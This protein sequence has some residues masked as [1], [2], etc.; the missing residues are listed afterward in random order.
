MLSKSLIQCS[1]DGRGCVPSLLFDLRP[2]YGGGN[3]DN[4]NLLQ[5]FPHTQCC[6]QFPRPCSRPPL[7]QA[8]TSDSWTLTSKSGSVSAPP[9][10]WCTQVSVCALQESVPPVLCKFWQFYGGV[11]GDLLQEGLCRTQVYCMQQS[12]YPC[13]SSLLTCTSAGDTLT[14]SCLSL[15]GV[16]WFWCTQDLFK[17]SQHL[18]Q[19][20]GLILNVISSL[21]PTCLLINYIFCSQRW[22]SSTQS[23]KTRLGADSGSDRELLTAKFRLKLQKVG[24]TTR[25]FR[26]DL[27]QILYDFTVVVRNRFKGFDPIDRVPENYGWKFMTLYRRQ[28]SRPSPR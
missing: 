23:A 20:W 13:S 3:E 7:T 5:K 12:P 8:S 21:L 11:N 24:K 16:S 19:V 25:P 28:G 27:H 15:I 18:W 6:T 22:R 1:L 26:D 9:G 2:T 14:Q 17:P 10:S 4:G